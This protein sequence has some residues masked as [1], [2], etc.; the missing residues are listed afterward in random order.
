MPRQGQF[1][2]A[3]SVLCSQFV[4]GADFSIGQRELVTDMLE[5]KRSSR[6]TLITDKADSADSAVTS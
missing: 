2:L 5:L 6:L 3:F 4:Q 1:D